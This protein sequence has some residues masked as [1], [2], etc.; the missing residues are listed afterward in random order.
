[1]ET[2]VEQM[3]IAIQRGKDSSENS[4]RISLYE[5]ILFYIDNVALPNEKAN[6]KSVVIESFKEGYDCC[7]TNHSNT[8]EDFY[9]LKFLKDQK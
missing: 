8:P 7:K 4:E 6:I 5:D 1:M 3:R 2:P 9:E